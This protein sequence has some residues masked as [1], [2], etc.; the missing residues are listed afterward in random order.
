MPDTE[1]VVSNNGPQYSSEA[2]AAFARQFRFE[3][4]TSSPHYPQSNGEAEWAVQ[5][6][7]NLLKKEGDSYL[8]LLSYRSTPLNV[9]LALLMSRNLQTNVPMTKESIKPAAPDPALLQERELYRN[10]VHENYDQH[11]GVRDLEPLS[12]EQAVWIPDRGKAAQEIQEA[13]TP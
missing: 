2:Y 5:T 4:V 10:K 13:G 1:V 12:P 6:V 3:H 7:K 11:Y 9:S 8:A